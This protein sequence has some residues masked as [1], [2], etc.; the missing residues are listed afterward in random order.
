MSSNNSAKDATRP[1]N[2]EKP[3]TPKNNDKVIVV[4]HA[5]HADIKKVL[6]EFCNLYNKD[7]Y[8]AMPR[9]WQFSPDSFVV[10]FPFD[11]DFTTFCFAVNFLKYPID[12]KWDAD[13]KGWTTT[14]PGDDWI[15]DENV[16]KK[17]ML[18]LDPHDKEYDNVFITTEENVV[19]KLSFAGNKAKPSATN[20]Q[21][22]YHAPTVG[23]NDLEK[24]AHEDFS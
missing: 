8:A 17:V 2:L 14:K 19:Y 20:A 21:S 13:V 18:Y 11:T 22:V 24:I 9:L 10:T 1:L 6:I 7:D 3:T 23:L 4:N 16:N 15:T 12:I 5:N